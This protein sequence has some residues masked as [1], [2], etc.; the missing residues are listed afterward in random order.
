METAATDANFVG[1][2][3]FQLN[4][5]N[6]LG[7]FD[8]ENYQIGFLDGCL[9]EYQEMTEYVRLTNKNLFGIHNNQTA[10]TTIQAKQIPPFVRILCL[11]TKRLVLKQ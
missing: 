10:P 11:V 5:Q 8:G 2:H 1:A 9:Q 7:R 6:C 3:F 4:D